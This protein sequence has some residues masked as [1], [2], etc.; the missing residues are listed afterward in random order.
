MRSFSISPDAQPSN[1]EGCAGISTRS[2][3]SSADRISPAMRGGPSMIRVTC[4][5][6][7]FGASRCSVSRARPTT[8]KSSAVAPPCALLGP[9]EGDPCG[10]ASIR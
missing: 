10:S 5:S 8:P 2:A 9:V 1:G 6:S 7:E 3:A 4:V